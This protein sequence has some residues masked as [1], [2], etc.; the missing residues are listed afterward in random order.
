MLSFLM[1]H[2]CKTLCKRQLPDLSLNLALEMSMGFLVGYSGWES[3][4]SLTISH[5]NGRN[6]RNGSDDQARGEGR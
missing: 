3:T 1:L 6:G 4:V 2:D 5:S